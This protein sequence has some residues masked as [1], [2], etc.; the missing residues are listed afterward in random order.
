MIVNPNEEKIY[1]DIDP[2]SIPMGTA[3]MAVC[4]EFSDAELAI[5]ERF[6][7]KANIV[8]SEVITQTR[9]E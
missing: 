7:S 4:E 9:G 6:I 3:L 2:Y 8:A 1:K 5:V